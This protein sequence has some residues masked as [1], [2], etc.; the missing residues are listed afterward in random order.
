[1]VKPFHQCH[2]LP[3]VLYSC[4]C[5]TFLIIPLYFLLS[6]IFFV[7]TFGVGEFCY[8]SSPAVRLQGLGI[9]SQEQINMVYDSLK[10]CQSSSGSLLTVAQ[11]VGNLSSNQLNI[12][13]Q[14]QEQL[15]KT[16]LKGMVDSM[17][18]R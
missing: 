1:M 17:D 2:G 8:Y 16:D 12:T 11:Q 10:T 18:V 4:A 15:D 9:P 5:P 13:W 7:V 3:I 14:I 6:A